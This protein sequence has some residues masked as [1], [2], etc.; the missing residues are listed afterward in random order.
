MRDAPGT[1]HLPLVLEATGTISDRIQIAEGFEL[2]IEGDLCVVFLGPVALHHYR[3]DDSAAASLVMVD[4]VLRRGLMATDVAAAFGVNRVTLQKKMRRYRDGGVRGL[5]P[6]TGRR[7]PTKIRDAVEVQLLLLKGQGV[8]DRECGRRLGLSGAG[9]HAALRRLGYREPQV[10]E[11]RLPAADET[12]IDS[13]TIVESEVLSKEEQTG[14]PSDG[15]HE[16][17][18]APAEEAS[19]TQA[20]D[21][22][23][24]DAIL[25]DRPGFTL[26]VDPLDRSL[27]RM[28][29]RMGLLS[30]AAP[31]FADA[32]KVPRAG[33]LLAL[34]ALMDSNVFDLAKNLYGSIGPAFYGLRTTILA[35]LLMALLR[36][37]RTENLKESVPQ[38][39]GRILGLDRAP[40]MKTLRRKLQELA[41]REQGLSLMRELARVR[42]EQNPEALAYF[43]VDGHVRVY[44]GQAELPKGHV[45]QRN[46]CMPA[47]TDY[48][49][50]DRDGQPV[51]VLTTEANDALTT[52]LKP[53]LSEVKPLLKGRRATVIFDRGGWSPKLFAELIADGFDVMTYRKG[54][55]EQV[56]LGEFKDYSGTIE[57]RKVSYKLA[58]QNVELLGGKLKMRQVTR[59]RENGRQTQIL[60]SRFDLNTIEVP[61]RM[62]SRWQQENFFKYMEDEFALDALVDY[63]QEEADPVRSVPNPQLKL[64]QKELREAKAAVTVLEGEYGSAALENNERDRPTMRGF[65][66]AVGRRLAKPLRDARAK[67]LE[68]LARRKTIPKRVPVQETLSGELPVKLRVETK[69]LSDIFK[70]IA[71]QAESALFAALQPHYHRAGQEGRTLL[72]TAFQSAADLEVRGQELLVTLAPLSSQHRTAAIRELCDK[73]NKTG[74]CFPGTSLRLRY[75]IHD[76]KV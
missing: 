70:M 9:I 68:F 51:L 73:L 19:T 60:T 13:G 57:G 12:P 36:I 18:A 31:V 20:V 42:A 53:V 6:R 17:T 5:I 30:D 76:P 32:T 48:W 25:P 14:A 54:K 52:I 35:F 28:M 21:Q 58:D 8:S 61:Y 41:G 4:L 66:T 45:T 1:Q 75:G 40:E 47:T 27:D 33:V 15:L 22:A 69:R 34:P 43:Y 39:L 72:T 71:Y 59:L 46:L 74:A 16:K 26:A 44:S 37:K 55:A 56:P 63:G 50:N 7:M 10:E 29:A 24:L 67:V 38:D 49:V 11:P 64:L 65:K 2:R 23:A 3:K 62:F